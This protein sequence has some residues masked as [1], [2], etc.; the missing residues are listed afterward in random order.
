MKIK[1]IFIT[2]TI[3]IGK[4]TILNK[5]INSLPNLKI[6][7]FRTLPIYE[8]NKKKGFIFESLDG[9]RKIFAHIDLD[10]ENHFDVYQFD[11]EV[12]EKIGVYSLKKAL[13][14]SSLILMDEIG[15]MEQHAVKFKNMIIKCLNS[16]AIVLGAFQERATWFIKIL[17]GRD[18][19][20]L[21]IITAMNRD[22][23]AE[24]I[25]GLIRQ[26]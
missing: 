23:V 16:S 21:F 5:V 11:D 1:N 14:E 3:H 12:F 22:L 8:N 20:K 6:G 4:S 13:A 26:N 2:G 15:M 25:I 19:T 9:T 24:Q 18:D 17:Q 10:A 7:G